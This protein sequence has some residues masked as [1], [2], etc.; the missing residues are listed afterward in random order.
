M[1]R[2]LH[3]P[4]VHFLLAGLLLFGA[5]RLARPATARPASTEIVFTL[6][7]IAQMAR[8]FQAQWGR[9]PTAA[10][11]NALLEA[12]VR[13]EVL[14][15]E[16]LAIGLDKDDEIVRRRMAQKMEFLAEDV[17]EAHEPGDAELRAWFEAHAARFAEPRRVSFRHLYFSPDRRGARGQGDAARALARLAGQPEASPL[18]ASLA[19]PF[20]FQ[21]YYRDQTSETL[22]REFGP[23]FAR[24]LDTLP[25]GRWTGPVE[26]GLGWHLVFV[27][28][29]IPGHA[30]T[31][32][33][34]LPQ[35]RSAWLDE[36]KVVA[37]DSVYVAMRAK[38]AVLLPG[39]PDSV[40]AESGRS[41][42]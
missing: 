21:D 17:A 1:R 33:A 25:E 15:R 28:G 23:G 20:M 7:E 32:E 13:E 40:S 2:F 38:Y 11:F 29:V 19:D 4:L 36:Q 3:E 6:D 39:V 41:A 10:E 5:F 37:W 31:L 35:A 26:S 9:L 27:D 22:S 14:Y 8:L 42:Q 30:T 34:V 24:A 16:A 18:A 12:E